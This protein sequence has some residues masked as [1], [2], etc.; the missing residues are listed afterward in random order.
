MLYFVVYYAFMILQLKT[1]SAAVRRAGAAVEGKTYA[2][3]V[4]EDLGARMGERVFL[5]TLE[6]MGAF[7]SALWMCAAFVSSELATTCGSIALFFRVLMPLFWSRGPG[8]AW[9]ILVELST[10]PYYLCVLGQFG[11]VFAWAAT[12]FNVG[13]QSWL[14]QALFIFASYTVLFVAA[15]LLGEVLNRATAHAYEPGGSRSE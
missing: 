7:L 6:Q 10:Q 14:V 3:D 5:N 15:F 8:G 12:G 9:N 2:S 11:A 4:G 13:E 1:R